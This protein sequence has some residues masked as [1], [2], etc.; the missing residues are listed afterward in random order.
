MGGALSCE[1][2]VPLLQVRLDDAVRPTQHI[3]LVVQCRLLLGG[4][5]RLL[6]LLNFCLTKK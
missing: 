4:H 5:Q 1:L 6:R 2:M 3:K